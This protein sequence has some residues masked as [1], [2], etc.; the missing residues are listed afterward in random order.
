[1]ANRSKMK[2]IILIGSLTHKT[3]H[4]R[5]S[6]LLRRNLVSIIFGGQF[7]FNSHGSDLLSFLFLKLLKSDNNGQCA[8]ATA[9][10]ADDMTI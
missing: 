6:L 8:S 5:S 10:A 7:E 4:Q 2:R 3:L 1:M 9:E